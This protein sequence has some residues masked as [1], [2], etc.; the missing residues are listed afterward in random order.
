MSRFDRAL[1][2]LQ[3]SLKVMFHSVGLTGLEE[4]EPIVQTIIGS[5]CTPALWAQLGLLCSGYSTVKLRGGTLAD[6]AVWEVA[7]FFSRTRPRPVQVWPPLFDHRRVHIGT[8]LQL[9]RRVASD[10]EEGLNGRGIRTI[11]DVGPW[12]G[13][14]FVVGSDGYTR[15]P[16]ARLTLAVGSLSAV[17]LHEQGG[18]F[19][20]EFMPRYIRLLASEG[21]PLPDEWQYR[22]PRRDGAGRLVELSR[23]YYF[24]NH[25]YDR[26][27]FVKVRFSKEFETYEEVLV[28]DLLEGLARLFHTTDWDAYKAETPDVDVRFD[29]QDFI[30]LNHVLEGLYTRPESEEALL[31]EIKEGFRGAIRQRRVLYDFL[32]RIVASKWV[33]NLSW[34]I[35]QTVLGIKRYERP[36]SLSREIITTPLPARLMIPVYRHLTAYHDM[37][38]ARR[39]SGLS[40]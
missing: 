31:Q 39:P 18:P 37:I 34:A 14:N 33:E 30:S 23:V 4:I 17:P 29:I 12:G 36:F 6:S 24:P 19:F 9:W 13:F 10:T 3:T 5:E 22:N 11:L 28:R 16:F 8:L 27:T 21:L 26:R 7:K 15:M 40:A 2:M 25:T 20:E 35:A 38:A 1:E 32:D